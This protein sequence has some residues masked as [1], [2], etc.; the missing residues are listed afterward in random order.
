MMESVGLVCKEF[1]S[2]VDVVGRL[3]I[4][5]AIKVLMSHLVALESA[6]QH[7]T[8][9]VTSVVNDV[10][11]AKGKPAR[12]RRSSENIEDSTLRHYLTKKISRQNISVSSLV[13]VR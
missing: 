7:S 2:H 12:D 6:A 9:A 11:Q 10:A 3:Q 13:D 8:A 5:S 4:Q 1:K